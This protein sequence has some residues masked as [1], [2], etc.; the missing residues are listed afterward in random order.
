[1]EWKKSTAG[2]VCL[3]F[4]LSSLSFAG[5]SYE[6][7]LALSGR[8]AIITDTRHGVIIG[9]VQSTSDL[10]AT[11]GKPPLVDVSVVEVLRGPA[12][13]KSWKV[14]WAPH[15][16]D[17]DTVGPAQSAARKAWASSPLDAPEKG[18]KWILVGDINFD[19]QTFRVFPGARFKY[20]VEERN[21]IADLITAA[22]QKRSKHEM[23]IQQEID[24]GAR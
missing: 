21:R 9:V 20:S 1:M 13:W 16:H 22:D 2:T 10:K 6:T 17:I 3:L 24:G 8:D 11:N 14:L 18:S 19:E 5:M 15:P 4:I 23:E 7:H 12:V